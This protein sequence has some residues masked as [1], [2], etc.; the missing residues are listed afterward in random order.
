MDTS[1][2]VKLSSWAGRK[3][4]GDAHEERVRRE[5]ERRGWTVM[6]YGQGTWPEPI[7]A[8][9]RRTESVM[10]WEPDL[11]IA[12][13]STL[14]LIDCKAAMRGEDAFMYSISRKA[15]RAH[16]RMFAERDLPIF[17]VFDNL[18]V[19]TPPEVMQNSRLETIGDAGGYLSISS[20]YPRPFDDVFGLPLPVA[21][22]RAMDEAA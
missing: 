2:V 1:N 12:Q 21:P 15:L 3:A 5:L 18:G 9:L 20:G 10:R 22:I 11:L 17:Y 6:P 14:R 13:G 16:V 8:A 7:R 19:L 4:V